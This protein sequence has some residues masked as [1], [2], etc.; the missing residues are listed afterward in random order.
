MPAKKLNP[1]KIMKLA[2]QPIRR[3]IIEQLG[4]KGPLTWKELSNEVGT[5]TGPL[6]FHL[7]ILEDI[8][9]RDSSRRYILTEFGQEVY[10]LLEQNATPEKGSRDK[11]VE[12]L[13]PRSIRFLRGI[14]A[15][16]S[17]I[18]SITA[19]RQKSIVSLIAVSLIVILLSIYSG[20]AIALFAFSSTTSI[21]VSVAS[22]LLSFLA[23]FVVS[24]SGILLFSR[25]KPDTFVLLASA[26]LSF[27]PIVVFA[28]LLHLLT[29]LG[30]FSPSGNAVALTLLLVVLQA[31]C[32]IIFGSG[33]SVAS[34][35]RIERTFV[36]GTI[37][38][39]I[40]LVIILLQGGRI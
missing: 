10:R 37:L 26:S 17:L 4:S 3:R 19:S 21:F 8:V 31:W 13:G 14:L 24:Y 39:Y 25:Q 34:G 35:L 28:A 32:V 6:Y 18:Y 23:V 29:G 15:P 9:A 2:G 20:A 5:G 11:P 30:F 7:D 16:R 38:M 36:T 1:T 33:V 22:Y 27:L 40:S 12:Y